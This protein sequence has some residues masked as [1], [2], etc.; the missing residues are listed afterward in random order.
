MERQ[1][2]IGLAIAS[3]IL[4]VLSMLCCFAYGFGVVPGVIA[5]VFGI[6]C[7]LKG[8]GRVRIM[9]AVGLILSVLGIAMG[10]TVLR[11]YISLIN[12]E[13]ITIS[14]LEKFKYIDPN[15]SE[16]VRNFLQQFVNQPLPEF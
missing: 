12:W 10:I 4:G 8:E 11:Y 5:A 1:K 14:N 16:A 9:G 13:S 15:D 7:V 3:I 2:H 6:I